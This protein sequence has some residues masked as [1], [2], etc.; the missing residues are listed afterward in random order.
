MASESMLA[1]RAIETWPREISGTFT[2]FKTLKRNNEY[3][4]K[5]CKEQQVSPKSGSQ[6]I[7]PDPLLSAG[8]WIQTAVSLFNGSLEHSYGE[9]EK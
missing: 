5:T 7:P 8:L 1:Q 4:V 3:R 6:L 9:A 2:T